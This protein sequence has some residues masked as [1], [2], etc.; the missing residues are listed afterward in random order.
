MT[1]ATLTS[2]ERQY[3]GELKN[4]QKA[5]TD[6]AAYFQWKSDNADAARTMAN[7]PK[8][9]PSPQKVVDTLAA[10][11]FKLPKTV[12]AMSAL[13]FSRNVP[14]IPL[15]T[16]PDNGVQYKVRLSPA[17]LGPLESD[18]LP[19]SAPKEHQPKHPYIKAFVKEDFTPANAPLKYGFE[20]GR[21]L[22]RDPKAPA[23]AP[24]PTGGDPGTEDSPPPLDTDTEFAVVL[25]ALDRSL[26]LVYNHHPFNDHGDRVLATAPE[27]AVGKLPGD[28]SGA[29][30]D[31]AKLF[32]N[33]AT[34]WK[35]ATPGKLFEPEDNAKTKTTLRLVTTTVEQKEFDVALA[36]GK[37]A[38]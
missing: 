13:M 19:K 37:A 12:A 36:G 32:T 34:A 27:Y 16:N 15:A 29:A 8:N 7:D 17:T 22:Y 3:D 26:W 28:A 35:P 5:G 10:V 11:D 20:V 25:N 4:A 21:L 30:F 9:A 18:E 2:T 23:P 6:L 24:K 31:V 33:V 1:P 14:L 38:P